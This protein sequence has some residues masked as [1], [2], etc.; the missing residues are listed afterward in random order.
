MP[1][2]STPRNRA[3]ASAVDFLPT[4]TIEVLR[5]RAALLAEVRAYFASRGYIEVETPLLSHD[6]VVDAHLEP[7]TTRVGVAGAQSRDELFLQTSPE[8]GMKRLLAAGASAIYQITRAFRNGEVGRY[9]NPEFTM[10][11]WY[12]TGDTHIE[13]M[14]VAE[15]LVASVFRRAAAML[16]ERADEGW[17]RA[18]RA[19]A[20]PPYERL[21][22][23]EA[24]ERYAGTKVLSLAAP[25]LVELARGRGIAAP[26]SLDP[27]DR[28][29]WLN[30]L[31]AE[32]VEPHLGSDL[33]TFLYDYPA[34]QAALA[35]VRHETP[36]VAE[37]FEL[38]VRGIELCNGYHELT[39]ADELRERMRVQ[40][41]LR[42]ANG[43]QALPLDN[44]LLS[45]MD[46]GLPS[47]AGVA[48]GFDRLTMLALGASSLADVMA[49][50][51]DRA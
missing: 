13:Q 20:Q 42:A 51:F 24:F 48:L 12:R 47:C 7:F 35:Q 32:L 22:Y 26:E 17:H 27:G 14:S 37:R 8:F 2:P 40:A 44:R 9:H 29:G 6:M 41:G 11:E 46:A 15:E 18:L 28:D 33:P 45:A 4:A 25:R 19:A 43:A 10:I 38:Y 31:L 39:D 3:R 49:F 5:Q 30:L 36:P 21:S 16:D 34:S 50:P 1:N 23:D